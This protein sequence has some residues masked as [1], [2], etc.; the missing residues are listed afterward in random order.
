MQR[1]LDARGSEILQ[2][3]LTR[4]G[5]RVRTDSRL[6][7]IRGRE[8][9]QAVTLDTG[10]TLSADILV[11]CVGVKPNTE[12]AEKAGL[13]VNQGIVVDDVLR[14]SDPLIFAIGDAAETTPRAPALWPISMQQALTAAHHLMASGAS[15]PTTPVFLKLKHN[16]ICVFR[17]GVMALDDGGVEIV[18]AP[19]ETRTHRRLVLDPDN[20]LKGAVIVGPPGAERFILPYL[21][22][23]PVPADVVESW[24]AEA[25]PSGALGP[26]P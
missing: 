26:T 20:R 8:R 9:M 22:D 10:E 4:T 19:E 7:S 16:G 17:Y 5:I 2:T 24:Q 25:N 23:E 18:S 3:F 15:H 14:T 13:A 21:G 1:E 12:L 6:Q 11:F